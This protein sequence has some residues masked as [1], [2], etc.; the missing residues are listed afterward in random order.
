MDFLIADSFTKALARLPA[1][2]QKAAKLSAFDLQIDPSGPG[3]QMHRIDKSKDANFWSA[4]AS[5]DLRLIVHKTASSLLLAF[6]GHHD[7]AYAWAEKRR[8]E[9]HPRT[10]VAQIVEVRERVEEVAPLPGSPLFPSVAEAPAPFAPAID[11]PA[12]APA[13]LLFAG[14]SVDQLLSVGVPADWTG[15][16]VAATESDFFALAGH[17]PAEAAEAQGE[18]PDLEADSRTRRHP[19]VVEESDLEEVFDTERH[20]L[21]RRL[22]PRPRP[23]ARHRIEAGVGV[24]HGPDERGGVSHPPPHPS[25]FRGRRPHAPPAGAMMR[26]QSPDLRPGAAP[27]ALPVDPRA[28]GSM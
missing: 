28:S 12:P 17:L 7:E 23:A 8:I 5:R 9:P 11:K 26:P 6:V 3:L 16:V 1:Q 14:L 21:D 18:L 15:D 25:Q 13:K 20:L 22:H 19:A 24:P 10:G 4:R 27:R 2:D